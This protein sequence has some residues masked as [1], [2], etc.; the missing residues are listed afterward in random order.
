MG[1]VMTGDPHKMYGPSI[2][3]AAAALPA[4]PDDLQSTKAAFFAA[5]AGL[6]Q[7][8]RAPACPTTQHLRFRLDAVLWQDI[9]LP[10]ALVQAVVASSP[11][12]VQSSPV[13][14]V[15]VLLIV[16]L[17][18]RWRH[19]WLSVLRKGDSAAPGRGRRAW[20]IPAAAW[21][22]DIV[23]VPGGAGM[24]GSVRLQVTL[25]CAV[26]RHYSAAFAACTPAPRT[27]QPQT[28]IVT[29]HLICQSSIPSSCPRPCALVD[30][31]S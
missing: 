27:W 7:Q 22:E 18:E 1:M 24:R 20:H 8:L 2:I 13:Q 25:W 31:L 19:H 17:S 12:H 9:A 26:A 16:G 10:E 30:S 14:A 3:A 28:H 29:L 5:C 23:R 4:Q 21:S 11:G 15:S 6:Q